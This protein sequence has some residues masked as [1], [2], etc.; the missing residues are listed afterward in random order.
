[1]TLEERLREFVE[2]VREG[3]DP[4]A[5]DQRMSNFDETVWV[6]WRATDGGDI[7]LDIHVDD[8]PYG[9]FV[10]GKRIDPNWE[11]GVSGP[12]VAEWDEVRKL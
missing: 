9:Y 7:Y 6:S 12:D 11:G 2:R 8:E 3:T 5:S 1:M 10:N 4:F